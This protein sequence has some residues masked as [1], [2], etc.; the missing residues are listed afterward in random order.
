MIY[1]V[2]DDCLTERGEIYLSRRAAKKK[3]FDYRLLLSFVFLT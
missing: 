3:L 2:T 1:S